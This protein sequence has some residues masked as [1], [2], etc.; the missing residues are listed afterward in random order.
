MTDVLEGIIEQGRARPEHPAV[1]DL[2]D[3]LTY[4]DLLQRV[5]GV[6][7]ALSAR[8]VAAG[9]RVA[10]HLPNCVDFVVTALASMWVGAIFVPLS[11]TDPEARLASIVADSA[12]AIVVTKEM[13]DEPPLNPGAFVPSPVVPVTELRGTD[14]TDLP[15]VPTGE[16]VAYAIYTSGTT[17]APKGV[18][19]GTSAFAA[20][21]AATAHALSLTPATRTLCVSPFYFDGSFGTLFPTLFSGGAVV[22]RPRASLL[23]PRTFFNAVAKEEITY[24][25]FSPSYL[26]LL[27]AS[28]QMAKLAD[29]PLDVIALGGEASSISDI[30]ALWDAAPRIRVFNRYGPTETTIAVTHVHLTPA[31]TDDDVVPMG[32][33]HTGVS[34]FLRD[35]DGAIIEE[36]G[37]TGELYI[38]GSQLMEG[39][40]GAPE[41]TSE[42]LRDDIVEGQTVYRTGDLA[43]RNAAGHY[44]YVDRADR[45]IKRSGVR[46]SLVELSEVMRGLDGV[47]AAACVTFDDAG[48]LGIAAFVVTE[49]EMSVLDLQRA[50]REK[51]PETMLPNRFEVV[52]E[53]P[54]TPSSKLD[55]RLLL[56]RA[57]LQPLGQPPPPRST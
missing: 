46:I 41:L 30:R 42:V 29:S 36:E 27:L 52:E 17:G 24:T 34:F 18:L 10:L 50:A 43:Y 21:V 9:D 13:A 39:Y 19:I 47:G 32:A 7:A 4:G 5:A 3:D 56:S 35:D 55:E 31:L 45:V 44:V 20:A 22:I 26:R 25:G 49:R 12:P 23:F 40:W 16:R 37:R 8:G 38:G 14:G 2:D 57:G 48:D 6:A 33:P 28:P 51:L 11:V 15:P 53:L 1:K 54:L